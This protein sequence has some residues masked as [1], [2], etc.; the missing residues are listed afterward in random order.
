MRSCYG[1]SPLLSSPQN[2]GLFYPF[3]TSSF[4]G[5]S[6]PLLFHCESPHHLFSLS[7]TAAAS[8]SPPHHFSCS[9]LVWEWPGLWHSPFSF[10]L[11]TQCNTKLLFSDGH[12]FVFLRVSLCRL[13]PTLCSVHQLQRKTEI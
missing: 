2:K 7:L 5:V 6:L 11:C 1:F 12:V 13:L 3:S 8:F 10:K 9:L 4:W